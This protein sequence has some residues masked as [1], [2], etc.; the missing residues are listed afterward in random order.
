MSQPEPVPWFGWCFMTVFFGIWFGMTY[1]MLASP[2]RWV[3][4]FFA[5]P[6]KSWGI[7]VSVVDEQRL[8]RRARFMGLV[9]LA[10]GVMV[11]VAVV[12][13]ISQPHR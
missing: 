3:E 1:L 7:A 2:R 5:K 10:A 9:Y 11:G 6:W 13:S 12:C 8:K 4:W